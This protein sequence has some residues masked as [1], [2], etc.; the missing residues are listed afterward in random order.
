MRLLRLTTESNDAIFDN[1]FNHDI[2]LQKDSQ[3]GLQNINFKLETKSIRIS[4]SNNVIT[5]TL[6][7]G[8]TIRTVRLLYGTF[9]ENNILDLLEDISLKLNAQLLGNDTSIPLELGKMWKVR[10][11]D[12]K[13]STEVRTS[14]FN[15]RRDDWTIP[16]YS[17][18]SLSGNNDTSMESVLITNGTGNTETNSN[19]LYNETQALTR[20]CGAMRVSINKFLDN[21]T[22]NE[23][24]GF[25]FGVA[26]TPPSEWGLTG[27]P[28]TAIKYAIKLHKHSDNYSVYKDGVG[29]VA[30]NIGYLA[31]GGLDSNQLQQDE[32]SLEINQGELKVLL[33]QYNSGTD[34][35]D[36]DI[37]LGNGA[38]GGGSTDPI[39][40]DS[41]DL[42]PFIVIRGV[43]PN[44]SL[45]GF[46]ITL[47]PFALSKNNT[48]PPVNSPSFVSALYDDARNSILRKVAM[49][50]LTIPIPP[51]NISITYSS[52]L[53]E[54]LGY[55]KGTQP[56][57]LQTPFEVHSVAFLGNDYYFINKT[58]LY[59]LELLD[60]S[61]DSYDGLTNNRRNIIATL[62][63]TV[64]NDIVV[65]EP[66]NVNFININNA[67]QRA[68]RNIKARLLTSSLDPVKTLGLMTAT[69]LLRDSRDRGF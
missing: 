64:V 22:G 17:N 35:Y 50:P 34:Q 16:D 15:F 10:I 57:P 53:A 5:Y 36:D 38:T 9:T 20:G 59:L 13:I 62:P 68:L 3:I 48:F 14:N 11:I 27:I 6:D 42:F 2:L 33:S 41:T 65:Y 55:N 49:K 54:F 25:T 18:I 21:G 63:I 39:V 23:D 8:T 69:L 67:N 4:N 19:L 56:M 47:N 37:V 26:K 31:G 60:I 12:D 45:R 58:G 61:L 40:I 46:E 52:E 28:D 7:E 51:E 29:W 66:S 30:T 24:N 1:N 44:F 43:S 32:V